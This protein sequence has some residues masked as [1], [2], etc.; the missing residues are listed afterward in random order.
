MSDDATKP[1]TRCGGRGKYPSPD[2]GPLV[3]VTCT[4][5]DGSGRVPADAPDEP[6]PEEPKQM[7]FGSSPD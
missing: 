3:Q 2:K 6:P 7:P 5:C 4:A 1:C